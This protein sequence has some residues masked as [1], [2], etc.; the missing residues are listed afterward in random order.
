L[1]RLASFRHRVCSV[2][3]SDDHWSA[4]EKPNAHPEVANRVRGKGL[5]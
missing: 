4:S 2:G 5:E 3:C 1:I